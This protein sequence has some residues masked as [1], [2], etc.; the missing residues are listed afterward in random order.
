M[1]WFQSYSSCS[2]WIVVHPYDWLQSCCSTHTPHRLFRSQPALPSPHTHWICFATLLGPTHFSPPL[3]LIS[4]W[5]LINWKWQQA[6]PSLGIPRPHVCSSEAS[7]IF[8]VAVINC[9]A[10]KRV[11][12]SGMEECGLGKKQLILLLQCLLL[13]HTPS[14]H[15]AECHAMKQWGRKTLGAPTFAFSPKNGSNGSGKDEHGHL[16]E[17]FQLARTRCLID[18]LASK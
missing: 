13:A 6:A 12:A 14:R 15:I 5:P 2:T 10:S 9:G 3:P 4:H 18:F 16:L 7:A 8:R 11:L 1:T 17:W